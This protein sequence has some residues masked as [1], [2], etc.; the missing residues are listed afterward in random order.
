M[1]RLLRT[2]LVALPLLGACVSHD[3]ITAPRVNPEVAIEQTTFA[4]ALGVN[5]ATMTKAPQGYYYRD[6]TTASSP[7]APKLAVGDSITINYTG[8]FANG[9]K[10]D[11]SL[12]PN[13]GPFSTKLGQNPPRL[14][15]GMELGLV[16]ATV[17]TTR[18]LIIPPALGYGSSDY[19]TIPG[20]SVLVFDISVVSKQ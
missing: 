7:T 10:F 9:T 14:I 2:A 17:G 19:R 16:G 20:N 18:R 11:S 5:L 13:R 4:P 1:R 8:Y 3:K 15:T 12:D 6:L